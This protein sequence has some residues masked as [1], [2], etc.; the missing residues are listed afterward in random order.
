MKKRFLI[1]AV[2]LI[3]MLSG[4][5]KKQYEEILG[6]NSNVKIE[7]TQPHILERY[8]RYEVGYRDVT[9]QFNGIHWWRLTVID[10]ETLDEIK[11]ND[12][13]CATSSNVDVYKVDNPDYEYAY[14]L[15]P[16]NCE[17]TYLRFES[18]SGPEHGSTGNDFTESMRYSIDGNYI[19]PDENYEIIESLEE[20]SLSEK[21]ENATGSFSSMSTTFKD[22]YKITVYT[23]ES[24]HPSQDAFFETSSHWR[25]EDN[26]GAC[27]ISYYA[28]VDSQIEDDYENYENLDQIT[29]ADKT[30]KV[31]TKD[32]TA[33]L[34]YKVDDW[35][36]IRIDL[37]NAV[38]FDENGDR[39]TLT[40]PPAYLLENGYLDDE[41]MMDIEEE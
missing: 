18:I 16:D 3:V 11:S 10:D 34:L 15:Y 21:E 33:A 24:G 9:M 22:K 17:D 12:K 19:Y 14:I 28:F 5:Q 31:M 27:I 29:I 4:C 37:W 35:F 20:N 13:L 32:D 39:T 6:K 25:N 30:Y 1:Y 38:Q 2:L 7:Y 8:P 36:Y 26:S 40:F 41:I 23:K